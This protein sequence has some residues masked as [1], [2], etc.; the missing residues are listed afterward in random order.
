MR[1]PSAV[2]A[3]APGDSP[4]ECSTVA[5]PAAVDSNTPLVA[6]VVADEA[7]LEDVL[8][9]EAIGFKDVIAALEEAK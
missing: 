9:D 2:P 6:E 3:F 8:A 7:L 1:T 5:D 4:V